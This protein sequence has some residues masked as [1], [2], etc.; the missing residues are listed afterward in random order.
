M[1]KTLAD[2]KALM[3]SLVHN[4]CNLQLASNISLFVRFCQNHRP[5]QLFLMLFFP[6][7]NDRQLASLSG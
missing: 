5:L 3:H 4:A 7:R 2:V 1:K 6:D